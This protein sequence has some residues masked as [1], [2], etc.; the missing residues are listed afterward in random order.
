[1]A[2]LPELDE[3]LGV[4]PI[5]RQR[6]RAGADDDAASVHL[7]HSAE[8]AGPKTLTRNLR[9][10][11]VCLSERPF[12]VPGDFHS[13]VQSIHMRKSLNDFPASI[14]ATIHFGL[15]P[16]PVHVEPVAGSRYFAATFDPVFMPALLFTEAVKS[17]TVK[18]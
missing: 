6:L 3:R 2:H 9:A 16:R 5:D 17:A 11:E 15:R 12:S 8:P 13:P 1:M 18:P 7:R 4:H 14:A 10:P